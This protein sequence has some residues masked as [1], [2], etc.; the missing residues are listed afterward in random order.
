MKAPHSSQKSFTLIGL[1][2]AFF[3]SSVVFPSFGAP[4]D[5]DLDSKLLLSAGVDMH[6]SQSLPL[7]LSEEKEEE[8]SRSDK[9]HTFLLTLFSVV[10]EKQAVS[11]AEPTTWAFNHTN[12]SALTEFPLYLS[13][14][15]LLI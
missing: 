6:G 1:L 4:S 14:Q 11:P 13:K 10:F 12:A 7:P 9:H 15:S 3:L 5:Q 8:E 2:V